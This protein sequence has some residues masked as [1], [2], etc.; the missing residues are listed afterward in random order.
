[1]RRPKIKV[2]HGPNLNLLGI[3]E[4][5][6][7]GIMKLEEIERNMKIVAEQAGVEIE[8]YQSNHEGDIVDT[9]QECIGMVD[10]IIINPGA[11]THYSI[12]ILDAL[13]AVNLPVVEV[14]LSNIARREDYRRKSI[15]AEG[16]IGI[17]SGFGPYSYHLALLAMLQILDEVAKRREQH[18]TIR[19][20]RE[21][22]KNG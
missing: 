13:R 5:E 16:A 4:P 1:M 12:A 15:T 22:D 21:K 11:Y 6:V 2:I 20:W 3:R 9:I 14:H 19:Q 7:Y 8:F 18:E 17:V 10:G